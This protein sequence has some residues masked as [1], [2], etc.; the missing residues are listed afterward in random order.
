MWRD[1]SGRPPTTWRS[2]LASDAFA[3]CR[4][5]CTCRCDDA[6]PK[7]SA[8]PVV[9]LQPQTVH[10]VVADLMRI[11]LWCDQQSQVV[12]RGGRRRALHATVLA[13]RLAAELLRETLCIPSAITPRIGRGE[14][15][16]RDVSFGHRQSAP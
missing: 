12:Q 11:G 14:E 2:P 1:G 15:Q 7:S 10:R 6:M 8:E 16:S 13:C 4:R 9:C 3:S 5:E